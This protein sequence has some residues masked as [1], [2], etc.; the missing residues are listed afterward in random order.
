MM[1]EVEKTFMTSN[2][3]IYITF[4]VSL[5]PNFCTRK[6]LQFR[7]MRTAKFE[8]LLHFIIKLYNLDFKIDELRLYLDQQRIQP[9]QTPNDVTD[10][11]NFDNLE[12]YHMQIGGIDFNLS[13]TFTLER[14]I[15]AC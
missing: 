2:E 12:L 7:M 4:F 14:E 13:K 5:Y 1:K 11:E 6:L 3:K 15:F 10:L 8:K 9:H